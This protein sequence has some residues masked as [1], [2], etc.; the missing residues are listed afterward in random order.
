M[1]WTEKD[2]D[3]VRDLC[4]TADVGKMTSCPK[5]GMGERGT[6]EMMLSNFCTHRYCPFRDWREVQKAAERAANPNYAA[7]DAWKKNGGDRPHKRPDGVPTRID[8]QWQTEA[9]IAIGEAMLAVEN[10]GG[11]K[12]LTDAVTLLSKAK[13]RVADHVEGE[14]N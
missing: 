2:D 3:R 4:K 11:S 7:L 13:N 8:S 10:A 9:E 1:A 12:A 5:C 6:S 14:R